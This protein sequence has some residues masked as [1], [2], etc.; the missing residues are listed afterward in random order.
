LIKYIIAKGKI[1][2]LMYPIPLIIAFSKFGAQKED[3]TKIIQKIKKNLKILVFIIFNFF[4]KI[5]Y[6]YKSI[7]L[8]IIKFGK[9]E[10]VTYVR[11]N[12]KTR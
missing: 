11:G 4:L 7:M 12:A 10:P 9:K 5:S 2:N 1:R 8:V 6:I 3:K